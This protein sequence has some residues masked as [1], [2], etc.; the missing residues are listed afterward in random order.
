MRDEFPHYFSCIEPSTLFPAPQRKGS[1]LQEPPP[2]SN[3]LP[4]GVELPSARGI[5]RS[6]FSGA[7][8]LAPSTPPTTSHDALDTAAATAVINATATRRHDDRGGVRF[9][10]EG[11]D[12]A[13]RP[14]ERIREAKKGKAE[15]H[16]RGEWH[17][18]GGR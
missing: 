12:A 1:L 11:T 18:A 4:L 14:Q 9:R 15:C 2:P 7:Q 3:Q 5:A 6:F 13:R 17:G 16:N 8:F 10:R